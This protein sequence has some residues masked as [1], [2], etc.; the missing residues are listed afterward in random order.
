MKIRIRTEY[1]DKN[2][3]EV[4]LLLHKSRNVPVLCAVKAKD[5][6]AQKGRNFYVSGLLRGGNC[7]ARKN[8]SV[9]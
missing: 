6:V 4:R 2:S 1:C 5:F 3:I 7:S 8:V 9:T